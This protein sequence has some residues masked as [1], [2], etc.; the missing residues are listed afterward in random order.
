VERLLTRW[1]SRT[2]FVFA[3]A[4]SAVGLGNLW[5]FAYL[6]GDNGGAPFLI[7][8]LVCLFLL[9]VPVMIAEVVLGSQGRA[10]PLHAFH[11][12]GAMHRAG[13]L[14][15]VIGGLACL[16]GVVMLG[17]YIVVAGW[18]LRYAWA[19]QAGEFAAASAPQ[20]AAFHGDLLQDSRQMLAWQSGFLGLALLAVAA[21]V[22]R[23]I[24]LLVW[25][26]VP[27]LMVLLWLLVDY[28][29][30]HGDTDMAGEFLFS[31][32]WLDFSADS[33]LLAMGHAFFTLSVGAAIGVAY[34]AYAPDRVPVGRSIMAVAIFDTAVAIAAG[35]AIF[36]VLFANHMEPA[37][38]PALLFLSV[39]YAFGNLP[40]GE[41]YGA[42]FF[43]LTTLAALGSAVALLEPSV[44]SLLQYTRLRRWQAALG[45]AVIVWMLGAAVAA[46]LGEG[47]ELPALLP[48]LDRLTAT[49]L[50]PLGALAV[51]VLVGA[52][53][54]EE[55]LRVEMYRESRSL[56]LLW[57]LLLRCVAP[58]VILVVWFRALMPD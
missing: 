48:A 22:R 36:P 19:L 53:L 20:V 10:S 13:P 12:A 46:S 54:D 25:L 4:A 35:I 5:R 30:T 41:I 1:Q 26:L 8:Y 52:Y 28:A 44:S 2:T 24:G 39:P 56:F 6:M 16:T 37:S 49:F 57:L 18:G 33:V 32:Q 38:G 51:A 58:L 47:S 11:R 34:G 45:V 42:L 29:L 23:G 14:W 7:S 17:Y 9:G 27:A 3:L 55:R 21:G 50:L 40:Q 43:L 15:A 31:V